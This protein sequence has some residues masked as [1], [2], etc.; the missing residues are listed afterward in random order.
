MTDFTDFPN[1]LSDASEYLQSQNS[2]NAQ[3]TGSVAD[4]SRLV[5]SAEL[6]FNLKEI[7]CSLMAGRGLML[8]NT[9]ICL[10]LNLKEL[11]KINTLQDALYDKLQE[12]DDAFDQFLDHLKLDQVLGRINNILGEITNIANMINFCSAPIDPVQIPNVLESAMESFL[13]AGMDIINKIGTIIPDQISG[14][15]IDGEF[16]CGIYSEGLFKTICENYD[17]IVAGQLNS[18][19]IESITIQIDEIVT[20]IES[21]IDRETNVVSVYDT[22]GSELAETPR[23]TYTGLGTLYNSNDEGIQGASR[24]GSALWSAYQ[25]LGSYQVV[26]NNGVVYNNIFELFVDEDLLRILRRTPD[27]TPEIS[28]QVPIYNYCNEIIG[29]QTV[30]SQ[31]AQTTSNGTTPGEIDQP[32]Y[33][34]GGISTNPVTQAQNATSNTVVNDVTNIT[35][36][37]GAVAIIV[38]S[39]AAQ[40]LLN[41]T[42]GQMVWRS[43]QQIMYINN[44][45]DT[46]TLS[47]YD[48]INNA[49]TE[50]TKSVQT[51]SS[52]LVEVMFNDSRQTPDNNKS[53]FFTIK[54]I[55]NNVVSNNVTAITVSGLISN[56]NGTVSILGT[57]DNKVIFNDTVATENYDI[58]LDVVADTE[59]RIQ[60]QGDDGHDVNWNISMDIVEA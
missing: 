49:P 44:G 35:N 7:I 1:G 18:I 59:F 31:E 8:P 22:G 16:N 33:N 53:W 52:S 50:F 57:D 2:V 47:D 41:T 9:Q 29:Y 48:A 55:A 24:N 25:Q 27:P 39:D 17:D 3:L 38:D 37:D 5:V 42:E 10:S 21:L 30:V 54:G 20:D 11:L 19:V 45:N 51:A 28:E 14:C 26:D 40:L 46:S 56:N 23:T 13:G 15:L 43:D 34:A 6:D 36:V 4:I 58:L 12:L 32:G 60:I